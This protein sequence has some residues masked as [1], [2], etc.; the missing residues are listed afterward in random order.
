MKN[1]I[2]K[3]N[4]INLIEGNF[5]S[6]D[7]SW[8][9]LDKDTTVYDEDYN[10][11]CILVKNVIS[12]NLCD[13][14]VQCYLKVG[15]T[16]STNRG[17][18][19]GMS[20]NRHKDKHYEKGIPSNSGIIGYLDSPNHKRPCRLSAYSR[21]YFDK[22]N[23]G[24]EFINA[25]N[26][27]YK[28]YVNNCYQ[29]Q[30]EECLKSGDYII[31]YNG[32]FTAFSTVTINYNFRTALHKDTGD[33]NKGFGNIVAISEGIEGGEILIPEYKIAIKLE[34]GD[35]L[36]LN[37]HEYHCNNPI[38]IVSKDGFRLSFVCYLREKINNCKII[39]DR[40]MNI[41]GTINGKLW[42]TEKIFKDIFSGQIPDKQF[43][44]NWWIMENER[45]KLIYKNKRYVLYDKECEKRIHNLLPAW[46]YVQGSPPIS[47]GLRPPASVLS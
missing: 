46:E 21:E 20:S 29:K 12:K 4:N 36:A 30:Y 35:Y 42:N 15:Q 25:I 28:T 13:L 40:L 9:Y 22:Y 16:V 24:L 37:V 19:A 5:Y 47:N 2:V 31:K 6:S 14:A 41:N 32:N 39:N 44:E 8:I 17:Y 10:L 34:T 18:A 3:K 38:K 1:I 27:C 33:Y 7:E 26:E 43:K 45:Y 23:E 11:L